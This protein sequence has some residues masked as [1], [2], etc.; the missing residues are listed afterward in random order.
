[1]LHGCVKFFH[2]EE[3]CSYRNLQCG[4][5]KYYASV[6]PLYYYGPG[7]SV[8]LAFIL[9]YLSMTHQQEHDHKNDKRFHT[10]ICHKISDVH[11]SMIRVSEC[12]I[13]T[14]SVKK[15]SVANITTTPSIAHSTVKFLFI[16]RIERSVYPSLVLHVRTVTVRQI[17]LP[18]DLNLYGLF[19]RSKLSGEPKCTN[20]QD[21]A[22][23]ALV[24]SHK[25][26]SRQSSSVRDGWC[27]LPCLSE[28]WSSFTTLVIG[29]FELFSRRAKGK[30]N[31]TII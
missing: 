25:I 5:E 29:R 20:R 15:K 6:L 18:P 4:V 1:M 27:V 22:I 31:S 12:R 10:K 7:A 16:I 24:H 19:Q 9:F 3:K 2:T 11:F 8:L 30:Y 17:H 26:T 13:E 23:S 14:S 21:R 28:A